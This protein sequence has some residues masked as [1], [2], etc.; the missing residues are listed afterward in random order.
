[1]KFG[2]TSVGS[3]ARMKAA[4]DLIAAHGTNRPV[5]AVVSA[6]SKVTDLLLD[7]T[8]M[9]EADDRAGMDANLAQLSTRHLEAAKELVPAAELERVNGEIA[10]LVG[11]FHRIANGMQMLGYRPARAVDEAIAVGE[12]LS[13][14]LVSEHLRSRGLAAEAVNAAQAIVTDAAFNNASPLMDVTREKARGRLMPI[15]TAGGI[16]IV[17][18]FNGATTDGRPTTLGRGG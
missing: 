14:L 6:M 12:R 4:A 9:A 16:P 11:E 7:T 1:M 8:R 10:D 17:T 3:A 18:G 2:G 13:A 15:L 5:T